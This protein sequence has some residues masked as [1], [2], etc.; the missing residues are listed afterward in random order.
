MPI[1]SFRGDGDPRRRRR[2]RRNRRRRRRRRSRR[3]RTG[4]VGVRAGDADAVPAGSGGGGGAQRRRPGR[5]PAAAASA[6]PSGAPPENGRPSRPPPRRPARNRYVFGVVTPD[7]GVATHTPP[8]RTR[9]RTSVSPSVS[10]GNR[11]SR[12]DFACGKELC[13]NKNRI[14]IIIIN[15]IQRCVVV[16]SKKKLAH[17]FLIIEEMNVSIVTAS[18]CKA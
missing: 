1:D 8:R 10:R 15:A 6:A 14:G 2:S 3:R 9:F 17:D 13:K 16:S 11:R 7:L 12:F 4:S 5:R 18:I